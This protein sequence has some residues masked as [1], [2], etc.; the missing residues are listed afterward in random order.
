MKKYLDVHD[1]LVML[2]YIPGCYPSEGAMHYVKRGKEIPDMLLPGRLL[3]RM[4]SKTRDTYAN[5][6]WTNAAPW[7]IKIMCGK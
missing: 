3:M 7:W 1:S 5:A 2:T 6:D 4:D